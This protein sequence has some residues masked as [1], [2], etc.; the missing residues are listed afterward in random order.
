MTN[1]VK[2]REEALSR[3]YAKLVVLQSS[4][5][6]EKSE[7]LKNIQENLEN[8][9]KLCYNV[10]KIIGQKEVEKALIKAEK[11]K[12]EN[13][14]FLKDYEKYEDKFI[15]LKRYLFDIVDNASDIASKIFLTTRAI[16]ERKEIDDKLVSEAFLDVITSYY[17]L[18]I[19]MEEL[20]NVIEQVQDKEDIEGFEYFNSTLEECI[21][22]FER[23]DNIIENTDIEIPRLLK[24]YKMIVKLG[25]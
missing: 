2:L 6:D 25:L 11:Y 3:I 14:E 20:V 8:L 21:E 5:E 4:D 22:K 9:D 17:K 13:K 15:N 10:Q 12:E 19:D 23:M 18:L 1:V 7:L 16:R 24:K